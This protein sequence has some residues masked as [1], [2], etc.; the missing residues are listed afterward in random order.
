MRQTGI[1]KNSKKKL[2]VNVM[3]RPSVWNQVKKEFSL[4]LNL[5]FAKTKLCTALKMIT[6]MHLNPIFGDINILIVLLLTLG[7]EQ[8]SWLPSTKYNFMPQI[9]INALAVT[10]SG[11]LKARE[12][13]VAGYPDSV[14]KYCTNIMASHHDFWAWKNVY[15]QYR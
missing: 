13:M 1:V 6:K 9:D 2:S 14:I 4:R 3:F 8:S 15:A 5:K 10:R 11:I 12:F 7:S